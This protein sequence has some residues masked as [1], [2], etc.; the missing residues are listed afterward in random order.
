[1]GAEGAKK[2][3]F[4][5]ERF[6]SSW[7][8]K[9]NK[10]FED[11]VKN[12]IF[13]LRELKKRG[14]VSSVEEKK[15]KELIKRR[16]DILQEA[17]SVGKNVKLRERIIRETSEIRDILEKKERKFRKLLEEEK[18]IEKIADVLKRR[19]LIKEDL[20]EKEQKKYTLPISLNFEDKEKESYLFSRPRLDNASLIKIKKLF[21]DL[22][23]VAENQKIDKQK[24]KDI[25]KEINDEEVEVNFLD[26]EKNLWQEKWPLLEYLRR[27]GVEHKVN[28][29][30]A[31]A[32]DS[33]KEAEEISFLSRLALVL[34]K[35]VGGEEINKNHFEEV[36]LKWQKEV[37]E[38]RIEFA[39]NY[40]K[41]LA[42][43][44]PASRIKQLRSQKEEDPLFA[45]F[46]EGAGYLSVEEMPLHYDYLDAIDVLT[47]IDLEEFFNCEEEE[48]NEEWKTPIYLGVQR[49]LANSSTAE[50][51]KI[52]IRGNP[53]AFTPEY[54]EKNPIFVF[55]F[56]EQ[57]EDYYLKNKDINCFLTD[58]EGGKS[59]F[60]LSRWKALQELNKERKKKKEIKLRA[61]KV[62]VGETKEEIEKNLKSNLLSKKAK[63]KAKEKI[64]QKNIDLLNTAA[65]EL[66]LFLKRVEAKEGKQSYYYKLALIYRKRVNDL[67][68]LIKEENEN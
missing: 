6:S 45:S 28:N 63:K 2:L 13:L 39:Y 37:I 32:E 11:Q 3:N 57:V 21:S 14:I 58:E 53:F 27:M 34:K 48:G 46:I 68:R 17:R 50:K 24:I 36:I 25:L 9:Q 66:S 52:K 26:K 67:K 20:N 44:D 23:K 10:K 40:D 29:K 35:E 38:K 31:L 15:I 62:F 7:E 42:A 12:V 16:K 64:I 22:I 56:P 49:T 55:V 5:Q 1:M 43:R 19:K 41:K 8:E 60:P 18:E 59:Y 61:D 33:F 30:K 51:K 65:R 4:F 54:P 47:E